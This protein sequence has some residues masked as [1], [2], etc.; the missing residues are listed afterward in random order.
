MSQEVEI[1]K[2]V[3]SKLERLAKALNVDIE[4]LK[5]EYLKLFYSDRIQNNPSLRDDEEKHAYAI[6]VFWI[7]HVAKPPSKE[8]VVIPFGFIETRISKSTG[9]PI[10]RI[11]VM[12]YDESKR[13]NKAV[14]ICRGLQADLWKDL[15]LFM[16]YRVKL[17][18]GS[19]GVYIATSETRFDDPRPLNMDPLDFLRK[20]VGVKLFKLKDVYKNLSKRQGQYIDEFDLKAID[21]IVVRMASGKRPDGTNWAFYI[22]SDDSVGPEEEVDEEGRIIP[23]QLT[24]WVPSSLA[25]YAEDSELILYGTVQLNKDNMP[26]MNGIGLI[27]VHPIRL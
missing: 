21:G 15:E 27:P 8:Y 9:V 20:Y 14:I 7:K 26:F 10:S 22:V 1:P 5:Q 6:R 11:Y 4:T 12:V 24:V 19:N 25:K 13:L 23:T 17:F 16:I 18:G 2:Y 3:M